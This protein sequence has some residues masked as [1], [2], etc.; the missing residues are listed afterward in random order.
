M[1]AFVRAAWDIN[2]TRTCCSDDVIVT[3]PAHPLPHRAPTRYRRMHIW[4]CYTAG[5]ITFPECTVQSFTIT[6]T[7][8]VLHLGPCQTSV[9]LVI[10]NGTSETWTTEIGRYDQKIV[11]Q[12]LQH[13]TRNVSRSCQRNYE[14]EVSN[15]A[16]TGDLHK[17][18]F[19]NWEISFLKFTLPKREQQFELNAQLKSYWVIT[20]YVTSQSLT[21]TAVTHKKV[22]QEAL[23]FLFHWLTVSRIRPANI[24]R[25]PCTDYSHVTAPSKLSFY[26]HYNYKGILRGSSGQCSSVKHGLH[27]SVVPPQ[28]CWQCQSSLLHQFALASYAIRSQTISQVEFLVEIY[29]NHITILFT[30]FD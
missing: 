2:S 29:S 22:E 1:H 14:F 30:Q 24:A 5:Q 27:C 26:Y 4:K 16:R 9:I 23:L 17:N 7:L 6:F 15:T 20:P 19:R 10:G 25:S 21:A 13:P 8:F 3:S 18:I 12:L 11:Q 28:K